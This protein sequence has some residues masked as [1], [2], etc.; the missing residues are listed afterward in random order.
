MADD[1]KPAAKKKAAPKKATDSQVVKYLSGL[2]RADI[3]ADDRSAVTSVIRL[4]SE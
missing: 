4:I 2:Q 3:S 1:K